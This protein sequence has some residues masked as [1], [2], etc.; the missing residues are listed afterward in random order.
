MADGA[1]LRLHDDL[2]Q[3]VEYTATATLFRLVAIGIT[4]ANADNRARANKLELHWQLG[5]WYD[6][7]FCVYRLYGNWYRVAAISGQLSPIRQ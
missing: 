4:V 7:A 1:T 2:R 5:G 6:S 3:P